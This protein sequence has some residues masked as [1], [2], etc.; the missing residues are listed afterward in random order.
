[1]V[2]S[3]GESEELFAAYDVADDCRGEPAACEDCVL[4]IESDACGE[5]DVLL[6]AVVCDDS[7]E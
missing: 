3:V 6:P 4:P 5:H 1:M 2:V 7:A